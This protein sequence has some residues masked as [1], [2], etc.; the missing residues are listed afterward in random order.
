MIRYMM[1]VV[2][3]LML[4]TMS[5]A[6]DSKWKKPSKAEIE[7]KLSPL[8]CQVTQDGATERPF[9]NEY[10]DNKRP[11]IYVDIVSGEPLFSSLDKFDSGSGWPSF[12]K[13]LVSGNIVTRVDR[14]L[15][16]E[17][18]EILSKHGESHLGHLFDDGPAPTG[19]R[20]C[21][22]SASLRFIPVEK[23]TAEGY[24]EYMKLFMS[25]ESKNTVQSFLKSEPTDDFSVGR[26]QGLE[27]ATLA[28]GCFWGMEEIIRGVKGVVKTHVGYT[29]GNTK[30]PTYE[31]VKTGKSGHAESVQILFDP[32]KITYDEILV[33]FFRMHDPT[34][35]NRQ[36]NDV[37]TQYR[38]AIFTYDETQRKIAERR[39]ELTDKSVKWKK[40]VVTS[41]EKA[42]PFWP[43]ED[44]HQ[45]YLQKNPKG[46]TCHFLRD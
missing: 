17:R 32:K 1:L 4:C 11:G 14:S 27:V 9:H 24:G 28:G 7:K 15:P 36:G 34:T 39:I 38:S 19:N 33:Y 23:L 20:Y 18:T 30:S 13:A 40:P 31:D 12:T 10:W 25:L 22:N 46:Y 16:M 37:G 5:M 8:Q 43:A 44:Y 35:M 21:V 3:V 41:I 42:G 2:S 6:A 45:S 29:G 26:P